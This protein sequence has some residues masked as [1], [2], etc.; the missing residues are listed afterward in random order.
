MKIEIKENDRFYTY[1]NVKYVQVLDSK[2]KVTY[3]NDANE[4][5]EEVGP[6]PEYVR[7]TECD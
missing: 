1:S 6:I 5:H 3:V 4:L 2:M 7:V